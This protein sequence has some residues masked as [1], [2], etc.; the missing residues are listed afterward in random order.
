MSDVA[1]LG[2]ATNELINQRSQAALDLAGNWDKKDYSGLTPKQ[3]EYMGDIAQLAVQRRAEGLMAPKYQQLKADQK[4][5]DRTDSFKRLSSS[6]TDETQR[7]RLQYAKE[8]AEKKRRAQEEALRA[9]AI[10]SVL[11]LAGMAAGAYLGAA[12]G[13]AGMAAGAMV[14]QSAGQAVGQGLGGL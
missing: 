1:E 2:Q 7:L 5:M 9:Q 8:Y 11:G 13:S 14:G 4:L 6:L 3:P 10:G 12:G